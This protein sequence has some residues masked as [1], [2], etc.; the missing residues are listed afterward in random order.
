M[1]FEYN[2]MANHVASM[3]PRRTLFGHMPGKRQQ[4][5]IPTR[6]ALPWHDSSARL[7]GL[8]NVG[9]NRGRMGREHAVPGRWLIASLY[10]AAYPPARP[11][12][13]CRNGAA[14]RES[15]MIAVK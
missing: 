4:E 10:R 6:D 14:L 5:W 2:V 7:L 13:V 15:G 12:C 1:P 3:R 11:E 9:M 8:Q